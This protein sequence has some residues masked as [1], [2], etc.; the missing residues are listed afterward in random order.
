[1]TSENTVKNF[2]YA[3]KSTNIKL[4][5]HRL[6]YRMIITEDLTGLFGQGPV[7]SDNMPI[8]EFN[9]PQMM[10]RRDTSIPAQILSKRV[11]SKKLQ[12]II[13]F[14]QSDI[15]SDKLILSEDKVSEDKI[16]KDKVSEDKVS[17]DKINKDKIDKDKFS[18][19]KINKDIFK[20][21]PININ[22]P[23]THRPEIKM[24][25]KIENLRNI[26]TSDEISIIRNL[27][28]LANKKIN[29]CKY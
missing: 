28:D 8:L 12:K 14:L 21:K 9:A 2:L 22:R 29:N 10:Y 20:S 16:D 27:I 18:E 15:D 17:E 4:L 6:F 3:K 26:W 23:E 1:M 5:D 13:N 25:N 24:N 7:H 19:D 11:L